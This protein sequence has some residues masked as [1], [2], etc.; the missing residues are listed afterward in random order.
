MNEGVVVALITVGLPMLGGSVA[1]FVKHLLNVREVLSL[2]N[3]Q[4]T[5]THETNLR[6]DLDFIRD[7]VLD[8]RTDLSWV[9]RDHLDLIKR[10]ELL[11]DS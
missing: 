9:R 8:L 11:E 5:N 1:W 6:E 7:V 3:E 10:V 4:V 2:V